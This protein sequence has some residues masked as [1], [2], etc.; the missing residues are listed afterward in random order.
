MKMMRC[1]LA[2]ELPSLLQEAIR[3]ATAEPRRALGTQIVRWIPEQ[4]IHLTL[5][6]LGETA[7]TSLEQI[8]AALQS[9]IPQ[10]KAFNVELQGLGAF[11]SV[12]RARVLWIGLVAP[13]ELASLQHE[14]DVATSRLGYVS[15]EREFSPHLTVGRV[16]QNASTA[17]LQR[18]REALEG[19]SVGH[20]GTLPVG[21]VHLYKSELL[22][23]GSV[24]SKLHSANLSAV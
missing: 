6:F 4:N 18:I 19:T 12:K 16:R 24:Y 13:V 14:L 1:F 15:E 11:P 8:G 7:P 9:G 20:V 17:D 3:A 5:K 23:S 21:A 2:V 10:Y 22:P